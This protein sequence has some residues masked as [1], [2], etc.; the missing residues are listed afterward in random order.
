LPYF[1]VEQDKTNLEWLAYCY[2]HYGEHRKANELYKELL[3]TTDDPDPIYNTYSSACLFYLGEYKD[4]E[5][6]ALRVRNPPPYP[7][8]PVGYIPEQIRTYPWNIHCGSLERSTS[9]NSVGYALW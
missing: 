1:N 9:I 3:R 2:F 7:N 6:A 4:A 5:E 8:N